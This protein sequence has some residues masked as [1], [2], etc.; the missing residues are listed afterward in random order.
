MYLLNTSLKLLQ[1]TVVV[2]A[3]PRYECLQS[4]QK[5]PELF[6]IYCCEMRKNSGYVLWA[7]N[8]QRFYF[9]Y[10]YIMLFIMFFIPLSWEDCDK[11]TNHTLLSHVCYMKRFANSLVL[12]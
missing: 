10:D 9:S 3:A 6:F 4:P 5:P 12:Q 1:K 8:L 7:Q 11:T 2:L